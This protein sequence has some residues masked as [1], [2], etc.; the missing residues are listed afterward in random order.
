MVAGQ[1]HDKD[2]TVEDICE[3]ILTAEEPAEDVERI[4]TE[5]PF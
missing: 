5:N 4:E 3:L 2:L 1:R